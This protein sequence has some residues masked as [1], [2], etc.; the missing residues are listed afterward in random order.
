MTKHILESK[1]RPAVEFY[2]AWTCFGAAALCVHSPWAVALAPSMGWAAGGCYGLVGAVRFKQGM[3]VLKY[4]RNLKRLPVY[5]MTSSQIP[6]SNKFL[7]MGKGFEWTRIHT[8]RLM[9]AQDP[10]AARFVEPSKLFRTARSLEM[11]LEGTSSFLSFIPK[12]TQ[13]D[14]PWNPVRPLPPVGGSAFIHGVEPNEKD[15]YT[16]LSERV[17]HTLVVG[18]TRVGKTRLAE[19]YVTQDIHR[20]DVTIMFDP[21]GD[22]DLLKRMYME[23]KRAGREKEFYVFHLG[24]PEISARYNAIGRFGRISEVAGRVSGQLSG[25]GNSAAFREFAWR[26]V[27]IIA[28]ALNELGHRPDYIQI[29]RHVVNIDELFIEYAH[30]AFDRAG[31][32]N[33]WEIIV[34]IEN[35]LNDKNIPRNMQGRDKRVVAV[36]QY[37]AQVGFYDPV[38]DGLRSAVR[39]DR[40]YFDKIVASLLPLLEKL[41]TGK[42]AELLAPDYLDMTDPRPIFDWMQIIRKRGV[43]YVGLDA[44]SDSTVASAVGN[45]MFADLV[46]VAG[47]IYKHGIDDG[48]PGGTGQD[49]IPINL[50][51]DEFNELMGDEFIPLINKGGGAGMQVTAYTQTISDIEARIGN[52]AKAGQ[53]VGNFNTL[54]MLRVRETKTAELLTKQLQKVNVLTNTLVSGATDTSDPDGATDFTSSSQDRVS[55]TSMPLLEPAHIVKLPKGQ[56]FSLQEGGQLWKVRMPLPKPDPDENLPDNLQELAVQM[57]KDYNENAGAWWSNSNS[58]TSATSLAGLDGLAAFESLGGAF[59]SLHR[60]GSDFESTD[61][62]YDY[63]ESDD[64][65]DEPVDMDDGDY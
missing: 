60:D 63:D 49:K 36:E 59:S 21:K 57:R 24:Y 53:V 2:T 62:H 33:A 39:Y 4:R 34:E 41:T 11:K 10:Q 64:D 47:H 61:E 17:G 25:E 56:M 20:G 31:H 6:V 8:Q 43:V 1:L 44:M 19:L 26:F 29:A 30:I 50:H 65:S 28:K 40:T 46:S 18:T 14:S 23:C 54:Q 37:I 13:F 22:A 52:A 32:K 45:S 27:N 15:A 12:L 5:E 16:P 3:D 7:F 48:V 51:A 35:K 9:D 42:T 58:A 55:A 38:M